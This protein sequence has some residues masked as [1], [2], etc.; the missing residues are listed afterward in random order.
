MGLGH[1]CTRVSITVH[2]CNDE[3]VSHPRVIL[4]YFYF[5]PMINGQGPREGFPLLQSEGL[6]PMQYPT[7]TL[8]SQPVPSQEFWDIKIKSGT[9]VQWSG[10]SVLYWGCFRA[11]LDPWDQVTAIGKCSIVL[12]FPR[13][14]QANFEECVGCLRNSAMGFHTASI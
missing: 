11:G 8:C 6:G 3:P 4:A 9:L 2:N 5:R 1:F 13:S 10:R 12:L 14:E 7:L